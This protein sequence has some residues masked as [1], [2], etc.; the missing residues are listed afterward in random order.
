VD[1]INHQTSFPS[2]DPSNLTES[3]EDPTPA[4]PPRPDL[5]RRIVAV[6][7]AVVLLL[8]ATF[9]LA[10]T[11]LAFEDAQ[12]PAGQGWVG[13]HYYDKSSE[14]F[15]ESLLGTAAIA[16]AAILALMLAVSEAC[17]AATLPRI[18]RRWLVALPAIA[19]VCVFAAALATTADYCDPGGCR[20][21][22]GEMH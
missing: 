22:S 19:A 6:L 8:V 15:V 11:L 7:G 20:D 12:V 14:Q 16:A 4:M 3:P 1:P 18:P 9:L 2:S 5:S 17:T 13:G 10:W 21:T